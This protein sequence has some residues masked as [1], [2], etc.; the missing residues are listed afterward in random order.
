[1]KKV[2]FAFLILSISYSAFS[3]TDS[4][5]LQK[6]KNQKTGAW[7]L[8]GIGTGLIVGGN[9]VGNTD[10][11]TFADAG[12]GF[13]MAGVGVLSGL[14]SIPLFIASKK[15]KNR[16]STVGVKIETNEISYVGFSNQYPALVFKVDLDGHK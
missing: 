14:G 11:S 1:M 12:T 16:A 5:Y 2:L 4:I 6:S 8:L 13:I 7:I 10:K 9:F 3:Q 15:N